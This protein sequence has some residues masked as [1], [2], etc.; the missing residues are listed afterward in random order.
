[1]A[2]KVIT[3]VGTSIFSNYWKKDNI[4]ALGNQY[5]AIN[6]L[7]DR[8]EKDTKEA[9]DVE[10]SRWK[11]PIRNIKERINKIWLP[12]AKEKA[13]AELQ[14][15]YKIAESEKKDLDVYL[16]ATDTVLSVVACELIKEWFDK[17]K[18][19]NGVEVICHFHKDVKAPDT[20]VVKGLQIKNATQFETE[21][22]NN[23]LTIIQ[24]YKTKNNIILN[25][26]GGY[27]AVIPYLTLF[28]QLEEIPLKYMYEDSG[29]DSGELITV[30]NLPFNFDF[31][32]FTDEYLAFESIHYTKK[33]KNAPSKSEFIAHL[34]DAKAFETLKAS[35][36]ID[37]IEDKIKLSVLGEMLYKKYEASEK[38]DGFNASNLLG[39]VMEI[40]VFDFFQK[41]YP[42]AK[43]VLGKNIGKSGEGDAYDIDVFVETDSFVWA[44]E[45]KPQNV[46][47]LKKE[48]MKAKDA[49]KTL[50]YKCEEG[51]F[52]NA[53]SHYHSKKQ[54]HLAIFMY[55]HKQPNAFQIKAFEILKAKYDYIRW[56]WL[57]PP[58]NYKGNVNWNATLDKF[59]E[60]HFQ[61]KQ[62]INLS[63]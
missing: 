22:F 44:I 17:N 43:L 35:F 52:K 58:N 31:S 56:I 39:K 45:V 10:N 60:Y 5:Q 40:Q 42:N 61:K 53:Y 23:L 24:K 21:G 32:Y 26:S 57:C 63:L 29:E 9:N 15:L 18:S 16:L 25:I 50:E 37:V 14:T 8:L 49:M 38:E 2:L 33:I 6:D 62:W 59:K 1:M 36:L 48:G 55:H 34:S 47:V 41:K 3:T 30:G 7:Y 12:H 28:A 4:E 27:K 11:A 46:T 13:S 51:A 19:V 20:T 54:V